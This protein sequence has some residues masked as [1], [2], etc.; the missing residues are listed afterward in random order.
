MYQRHQ[1]QLPGLGLRYQSPYARNARPLRRKSI[2]VTPMSSPRKSST[3]MLQDLY[4]DVLK[5]RNMID[6]LLVDSMR[7]AEMYENKIRD[8]D[9]MVNDMTDSIDMYKL[10]LRSREDVIAG[11][12]YKIGVL[13]DRLSSA[14]DLL[15]ERSNDVD[16][17]HYCQCC[18]QL[19][20][21]VNHICCDKGHRIC[22]TCV[23]L[24]CKTLMNNP[25]Y[26]YS[27]GIQ[28]MSVAE[29]D[30]CIQPGFLC[31]SPWGFK[32]VSNH[33]FINAIEHVTDVVR[34]SLFESPD[35][36]PVIQKR[37]SFLNA[38]GSFRGYECSQCG[39]GPVWHTDC[40]DLIQHHNQSTVNGV[41]RNTCPSCG[42]LHQDISQMRRWQGGFISA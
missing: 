11:L 17:R 16:S 2:V 35:A 12:F 8:Y 40:N 36:F 26:D 1:F 32:L 23:D 22:K 20:D 29:C 5:I 9:M 13:E 6:N 27:S 42:F 30:S 34:D 4:S 39:F 25:C 37:L 19:S 18:F 24:Y 15:D 33:M 10:Q 21:E 38:D 14:C 28:C 7:Q 31:L 3:Q 41:I